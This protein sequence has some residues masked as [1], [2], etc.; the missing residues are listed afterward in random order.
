MQMYKH[1]NLL[2]PFLL[3]TFAGI[4][5]GRGEW[6]ITKQETVF[7]NAPF[8]QCHAS[9]ILEN[10]SGQLVIACFGGSGESNPDVAIWMKVFTGNK[11]T[12]PYKMAEGILNDSLRYATWN[13]VLFESASGRVS[14]FYKVGPNPREWW[15]MV[16]QFG[17]NSNRWT[18]PK[19]LPGNILGPIKNKPVQ[20]ADGTI[21]SPSSTEEANGAWH[22]HVE[23]SKDDGESWRRVEVDTAS[24]Y[25]VI[26]PA[27]LKYGD[28]LQML[29]RSNQQKIAASWSEDGGNTWSKLALTD[30]PN[31]NSGIDAVTLDDGTQMLVYN[32][33]VTGSNWWDGRSILAV[34]TS[35][36]GK[37]WKKILTLENAMKGEFSYPAIIQARNGSVHITYTYDR[38]NIKHVVLEKKE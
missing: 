36:D 25:K 21:L 17:K 3:A 29:C 16:M 27:I 8:G 20:L 23:I 32:P 2:L 30:L 5:Q 34:A 37:S 38:K 28:R 19:K 11:W 24:P 1:F 18:P 14:L 4:A 9:T 35:A 7:D 6:Q 10:K 22:V 12:E 15:G 31:P 13:P 26:Q 33:T